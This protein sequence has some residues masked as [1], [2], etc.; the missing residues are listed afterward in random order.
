MTL[1][2]AINREDANASRHPGEDETA[3]RS[4]AQWMYS[5]QLEEKTLHQG[6][7]HFTIA[8]DLPLLLPSVSSYV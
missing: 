5:F 6:S 2:C 8:E 1:C 4:H 7:P 3:G